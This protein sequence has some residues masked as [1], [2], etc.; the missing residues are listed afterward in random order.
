MKLK[1]ILW[2]DIKI[3]DEFPDS[4]VVKEI[5]DWEYQPCY[6]VVNSYDEEI[7][8]SE[9]HI[10][11]IEYT[12]FENDKNKEKYPVKTWYG[13]KEI[14]GWSSAKE[15]YQRFKDGII[16]VLSYNDNKENIVKNIELYKNGERQKCRCIKTSTGYYQTIM[17]LSGEIDLTNESFS[18]TGFT[19]HNTT[20][21]ACCINDF[22]RVN[23]PFDN[24]TLISLEDPIEYI[25][26]P[27]NT[28]NILQ[29]E[30]GV[31]FKEFALGVKQALREHPNF[32]ETRD[33]E[34]IQTL[35]EASRTG[36]A[37]WT[38]F[39]ASGVSDT[40]ARMLNHLSKESDDAVYD[41]IN[42]LNLI[43][44]QKIK[45]NKAKFVLYT[46]YMFFTSE[47]KSYLTKGIFSHKSNTADLI[48]RLFQDKRLVEAG[49]VKDWS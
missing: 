26:K 24:S 38:S 30:L 40:I 18:V 46:Q 41:L 2:K 23:G 10:F 1:E 13:D 5:M 31:D 3:G 12:Y 16:N 37:V 45:S 49:I 6:I 7:I 11:A 35:L 39:H 36:H 19:N 33:A 34:T 48:D 42:N 27:T 14:F 17:R 47:I 22:S 44:C 20:T 43:V 9:D 21:M 28:V 32:G 25:Y 8:V 15:I 29:K 4:S